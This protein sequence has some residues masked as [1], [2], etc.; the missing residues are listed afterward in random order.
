MRLA[1]VAPRLRTPWKTV[2]HYFRF[3]RLDGTWER[4]HSALLRR[5][6]VHL[7]RMKRNPQPS[8]AIVD[9]QSVKTT[10]GKERG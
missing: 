8:A 4:M 5:V 3:W 9:S 6:R 1:T 2:Y 7:Q 10:G